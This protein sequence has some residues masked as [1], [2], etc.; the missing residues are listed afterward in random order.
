MAASGPSGGESIVRSSGWKKHCCWVPD[1]I[2]TL[3]H[4]SRAVIE[5]PLYGGSAGTRRS[6]SFRPAPIWILYPGTTA[7]PQP[8]T[9]GY[10]G[11]IGT[12]SMFDE[13]LACFKLLR[14]EQNPGP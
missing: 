9:L 1:H 14:K 5:V 11:S 8:Y 10:L 7:R 12:L 4:A 3:T 13:V 6:A 2:V